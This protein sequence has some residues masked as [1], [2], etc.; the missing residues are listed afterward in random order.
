MKIVNFLFVIIVRSISN[1]KLLILEKYLKNNENNIGYRLIL[2]DMKV[3][4]ICEFFWDRLKMMLI[5]V[6]K[7]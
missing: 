1:I 4:F 2:L 3:Y 7:R 5:Y 6:I